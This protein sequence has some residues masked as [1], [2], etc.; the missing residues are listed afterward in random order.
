MNSSRRNS[1]QSAKI[2]EIY[3]FSIAK[4]ICTFACEMDMLVFVV[5]DHDDTE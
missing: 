2:F 1:V 3:I 5:I 4:N